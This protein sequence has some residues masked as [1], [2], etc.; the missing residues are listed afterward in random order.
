MKPNDFLQG[1]LFASEVTVPDGAWY[2]ERLALARRGKVSIW[3]P[4]SCFDCR[5]CLKKERD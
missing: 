5:R 4:K 2:E 3:C 1:S